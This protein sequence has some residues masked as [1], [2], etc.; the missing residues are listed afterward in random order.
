MTEGHRFAVTCQLD[1]AS[2]KKRH[3]ASGHSRQTL[4]DEKPRQLC[5]RGCSNSGTLSA[6]RGQSLQ[7]QTFDVDVDVHTNT[8]SAVLAV[9]AEAAEGGSAQ[10][11]L[12]SLM[13]RS[14]LMNSA[15]AASRTSGIVILVS[16][17][18][19]MKQAFNATL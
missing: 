2:R 16:R 7:N 15:R 11:K 5:L 10:R 14:S 8:G 18:A 12:A 1:W 17:S 4:V 9:G 3:G 19:A 13:G 6:G